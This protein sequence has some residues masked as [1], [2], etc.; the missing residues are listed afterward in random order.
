[1]LSVIRGTVYQI[2]NHNDVV[3]T[4]AAYDEIPSIHA[5]PDENGGKTDLRPHHPI[6]D[7]GVV[8]DHFGGH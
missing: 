8:L 7:V 5:K 4:N 1:M 2:D 3:P 6:Q